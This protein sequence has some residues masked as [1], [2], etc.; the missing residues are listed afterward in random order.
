MAARYGAD[1]PALDWREGGT[2]KLVAGR[3]NLCWLGRPKFFDEV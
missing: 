1:T 2:P 3:D